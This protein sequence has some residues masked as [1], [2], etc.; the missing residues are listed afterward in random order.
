MRWE[1]PHHPGPGLQLDRHSNPL[2]PTLQHDPTMQA[3]LQPSPCPLNGASPPKPGLN[4]GYGGLA[5]IDGDK[6]G[7]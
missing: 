3:H 1:E 5:E 7:S 2:S 4:T 6:L